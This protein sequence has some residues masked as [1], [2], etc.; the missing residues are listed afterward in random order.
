V[1]LRVRLHASRAD[2]RLFGRIHELPPHRVARGLR[3]LSGAANHSKLWVAIAA[4]LA[5]T[6]GRRGRRAAL[7]GLLSVGMSSAIVNQPL[8]RIFRRARPGTTDLDPR[9]LLGRQPASSSFPSGHA[10]SAF[11]FATGASIE[12]PRL[13][14]PLGLTAAAVAGSRITVGAHYPGDVAVG[15]AGGVAVALLTRRFW[16]VAPDGPARLSRE[17]DYAADA[18]TGDGAG[19]VIA[20]NDGAGNALRGDVTETLR[21]ELP[22]ARLVDPGDGQLDSALR[23]A[24]DGARVVGVA[25]G[26]GSANAGAAVAVDAGLPLMVVPAGTLNHL[27]RDLGLDTP[28]DSIESLRAGHF[29]RMDVGRIAGKPFLNTASIGSYVDLVEARERL[30]GRIGKWPALLVA[31][32]RVLRR[33]QPVALEIDGRERSVWLVFFGNCTYHPSGFA[34]SWRER[35]DDGVIDV[36]VLD[37]QAPWS[38]TR[39]VLAVL[40]GRLARCRLYEQRHAQR[41]ELR[42]LDGPSRLARDGEIFD[43]PESF[44]VEKDA[45]S[46]LVVAH[47]DAHG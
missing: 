29:A 45:A 20:V 9:R 44:T 13:A 1:R 7:R 21:S 24:L 46:L 40:T 38:R 22:A 18:P 14:V 28:A 32:V 43:G 47:R 35:L 26:D 25:G 3:L 17:L 8:K 6:Q 39:L 4:A 11:A 5:L 37:A 10:A 23:D 16:P 2:Q 42:S 19:V 30:E 12:M 33:A 41:V 36:R 15:A 34:P 27:A 31:L